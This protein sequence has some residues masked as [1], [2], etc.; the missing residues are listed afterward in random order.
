MENH[1]VS[2]IPKLL[3]GTKTDLKDHRIVPYETA[4]AFA[5]EHKMDYV[6]ASSKLGYGVD[7][8]FDVLINRTIQHILTKNLPRI[9]ERKKIPVTGT[10]KNKDD[11][12]CTIL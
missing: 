5:D 2:D 9:P 6:E 8:A 1:S 3:I 10:K 4:K 12:C 11:V 7:Q